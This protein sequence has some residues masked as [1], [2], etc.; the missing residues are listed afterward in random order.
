VG[1]YLDIALRV[2]REMAA[3][4][5]AKSAISAERGRT[6]DDREDLPRIS[7]L[8]RTLSE[9]ESRC[10]TL[11]PVSRWQQATKDGRRFLSQWGTQAEALGWTSRDLFG[12]HTPPEKPRPSYSR[13]SRYDHTGLVWLLG[14][15]NVTM[16]TKESAAITNPETGNVTI[17]RR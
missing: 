10:P 14:G 11:V 9:L 3:Q 8:S 15:R 17:F 16:L 12:L 1:K 4:G 7:R 13:L 6:E 5:C 2:E